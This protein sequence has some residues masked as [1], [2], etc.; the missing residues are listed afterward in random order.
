M[1]DE[2]DEEEGNGDFDI[3]KKNGSP[4]K[5]DN[6]PLEWRSEFIKFVGFE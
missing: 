1:E 2:D 5:K 3:E 6:K 4:R